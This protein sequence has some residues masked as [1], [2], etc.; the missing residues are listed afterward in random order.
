[1]MSLSAVIFAQHIS[2]RVQVAIIGI[3]KEIDPDNIASCHKEIPSYPSCCVAKLEI[4]A[5]R[6]T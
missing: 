2:S 5:G 4:S 3:E 6:T 1:M